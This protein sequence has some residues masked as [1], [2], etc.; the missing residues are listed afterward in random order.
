MRKLSGGQNK[1]I[2]LSKVGAEQAVSSGYLSTKEKQY[3]LC[4]SNSL[5]EKVSYL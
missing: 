4:P 3:N 2:K 1:H 5:F